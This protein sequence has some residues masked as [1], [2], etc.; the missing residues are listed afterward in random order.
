ME[1]RKVDDKEPPPAETSADDFGYEVWEPPT[2]KGKIEMIIFY[3]DN[4]SVEDEE[5]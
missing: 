5:E 2:G 4:G 3:R 1:P